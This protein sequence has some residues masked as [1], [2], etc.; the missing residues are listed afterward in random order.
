[1]EKFVDGLE[2]TYTNQKKT[3]RRCKRTTSGCL[4]DDCCRAQLDPLARIR[5]MKERVF[6][7][8]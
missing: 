1:M 5:K 8:L 3:M 6:A 2:V 7:L 4:I